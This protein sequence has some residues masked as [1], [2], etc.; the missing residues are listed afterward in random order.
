MNRSNRKAKLSTY[1]VK[2][3]RKVE[4]TAVIQVEARSAEEAEQVAINAVDNLENQN[5]WREGDVIDETAK[6]KLIRPE[7]P[8]AKLVRTVKLKKKPVGGIGLHAMVEGNRED[9]QT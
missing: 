8:T 4:H 1:E 3:R 6:A 5:L 7:T 9:H 2:V